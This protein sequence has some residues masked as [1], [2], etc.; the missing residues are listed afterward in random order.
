MSKFEK[1]TSKGRFILEKK[2]IFKG[3][4]LKSCEYHSDTRMIVLGFKSGC[5]AL[6]RLE[7]ESDL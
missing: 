6:Y 2:E 4:K 1:E 5:Y 7:K 3:G